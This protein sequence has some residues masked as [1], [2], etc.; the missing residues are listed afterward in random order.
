MVAANSHND[1]VFPIS[2]IVPVAVDYANGEREAH[3]EMVNSWVYG[4]AIPIWQQYVSSLS[5]SNWM[6]R[7]LIDGRSRL[8][9]PRD[10]TNRYLRVEAAGNWHYHNNW[11]C[12]RGNHFWHPSINPQL[13]LWYESIVESD[14]LVSL[15]AKWPQ[16]GRVSEGVNR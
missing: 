11:D 5:Q 13:F 3:K 4:L 10:P 15:S 16:D 2:S 7:L 6:G 12:H 1:I 9:C 8:A 14:L